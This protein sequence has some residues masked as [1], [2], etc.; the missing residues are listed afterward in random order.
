MIICTRRG[1]FLGISPIKAIT[2]ISPTGWLL[3]DFNLI[4][5][6]VLWNV[7]E[8]TSKRQLPFVVILR[9]IFY[10][11]P[12]SFYQ[13]SCSNKG[14]Y[15]VHHSGARRYH[16]TSNWSGEGVFQNF[17]TNHVTQ[18]ALELWSWQPS[19]QNHMLIWELSLS[20]YTFQIAQVM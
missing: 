2:F 5:V 17:I 10:F 1:G 6:C 14:S 12:L 16:E 9:R 19:L 18:W 11:D 7:W 13:S 20:K 4:H 15:V 3:Q 8:F